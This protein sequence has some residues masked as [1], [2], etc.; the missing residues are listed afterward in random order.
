MVVR[1]IS[2]RVVFPVGFIFD[3]SFVCNDVTEL[4]V[5]NFML[6]IAKFIDVKEVAHCSSLMSL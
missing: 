4:F 6:S 5:S 1:M 3:T 2:I